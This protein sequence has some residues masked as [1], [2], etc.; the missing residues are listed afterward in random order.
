MNVEWMVN[1]IEIEMMREQWGRGLRGEAGKRA[2]GGLDSVK[3]VKWGNK[4]RERRERKM[5]GKRQFVV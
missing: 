5:K 2:N 1:V 3:E 4:V